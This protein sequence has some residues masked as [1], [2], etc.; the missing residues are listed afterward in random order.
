MKLQ[1]LIIV[2]VIGAGAAFAS[3][4]QSVIAETRTIQFPWGPAEVPLILG[5]LAVAGVAL[6]LLLLLSGIAEAA[7]VRARRRLEERL[8]AR[9]R[10]VDA[11]KAHAYDEVAQ[12]IDG[13]RQEWSELRVRMQD[14]VLTA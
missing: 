4:N 11:L 5:L 3:L 14:R 10:E 8:A 12:K 9:E 2:L 7:H 1:A 13:L 6:L